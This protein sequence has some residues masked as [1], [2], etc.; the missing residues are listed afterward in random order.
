[1]AMVKAAINVRRPVADVV[2][3]IADVV[4][5]IADVVGLIADVV[6]LVAD[7]VGLIADVVANGVLVMAYV[8]VTSA[9]S[10]FTT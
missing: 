10:L 3:L 9:E 7:V 5:L 6:G 8:R 2:G 4:G 1:M